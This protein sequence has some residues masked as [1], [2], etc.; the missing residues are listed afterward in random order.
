MLITCQDDLN[1]LELKL[2]DDEVLRN[3]EADVYWCLTKLLDSIQVT[4]SVLF[5][6]LNHL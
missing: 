4:S 3:M 2:L 6:N 5:E 1:S